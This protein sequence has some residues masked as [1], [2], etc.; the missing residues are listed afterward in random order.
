MKEKQEKDIAK[1]L[2]QYDLE[3]HPSGETL[4]FSTRIHRVHVVTTFMKAGIPLSK[5]DNLRELLEENSHYL[6]SSAHLRSLVPLILQGEIDELKRVIHGKSVSIV[7]DGTT[8]VCE[9]F[10]V[11]LRYV[12]D[13]VIKQRICRLMLLAKSITGE[14]VARQ[15]ITILSTELLISPDRVVGAMRDRA[16]VNNVAMRTISVIFNRLMDMPTQLTVLEST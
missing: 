6:T 8:H 14:E 12:N 16:S 1:A 13:W 9:A 3:V 4:P 5:V 2:W 11:L 10:V 15:L 7:F